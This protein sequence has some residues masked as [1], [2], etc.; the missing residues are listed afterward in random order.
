LVNT[1]YGQENHGLTQELMAELPGILVWAIDGLRRL[2][3]RGHF[4]QP[5]AVED[6]VREMEDLASPVMAFV[7][8]CCQ[9]G[10]GY[11]I[12]VDELYD[13]WKHWCERDGRNSI[14]IKQVFGRDLSAAVPGV[15]RRRNS[16]MR[17]FYD[18]IRLRAGGA[19]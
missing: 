17:A 10:V 13:E 14:T 5:K 4:V 3:E 15:L 12:S 11:R 8:E 1:F 6:A 19:S 16:S 9:V 18:G 2:R 7:R